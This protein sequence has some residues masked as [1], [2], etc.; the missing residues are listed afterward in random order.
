MN[1]R[2]KNLEEMNDEQRNKMKEFEEKN[3][4][5]SESI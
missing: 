1:N 5:S 4:V 3:K 2:K